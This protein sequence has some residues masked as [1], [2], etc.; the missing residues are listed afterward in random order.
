MDLDDVDPT[1]RT[2]N[3]A[4]LFD[5]T[6]AHHGDAQAMEHHGERT[7]HAELRDRTAAFAGGLHELGLAPGDRMLLFL[8]N[9][10]EYLV[11]SLGAFRAG[12]VF[13][14]VNPQY[15][16][17]EVAYQL[18]DADATAI[19]TH[20]LLREVVDEALEDTDREP[21]VVTI[22]S[23]LADRDPD[24]VFFEDVSGE[25]TL[26]E[27]TDDDVALLPYTSGTTGD[28]KGVQLTHRNTRA[29][30]S[31]PLTSSNVDVEGEDVRSLVWLPLYHIT[32]FTH[33]ALQPLVGGGSLYFRSALEWD[34]RE[35]M[36][37]IEDEEITHFVGVTTMYADMVEAEG[38][39]EYDLS[40]LESA[41]EGGAKLSTAVQERFEETAGVD[42][43]EGYGLTETHGAT[44][45]Q[46]GSSFGL[47]HGTIGQPLRMTDCKIV[48]E[49]GDE[50]ASGEEGELLVRGP[51]VMTGYHDMPE[52]TE[53]AFT[54][55]GYFRTG[56]IARR[57]E[58]N[59][60]EIVDRKKHV[61]VSAGYNVYPSE[62][63]ALLLE[64]EAVADVAVIGVPDDRRNEVPKAFVVPGAGV[65]PGADV[66]A[67]ELK[68]Y[69]LDRVA[70][71]KHPR[72]VE[73]IDELP[74]TTSGKVQKYKLE[75]NEV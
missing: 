20:P 37:L 64:H 47:R 71:Y 73:F 40:S 30:M 69:S 25:P 62:L 1:A 44:H 61:I 21:A 23:E 42:I 22:E 45:T 51:Q 75:A 32:G 19:V 16:R 57:D 52:A 3:V 66:T 60:Y 5:E 34:A 27:R 59:Y 48:D 49:S 35:C 8:P 26:V 46:L 7:T 29:Q 28:P 56:D 54:E 68:R 63:E 13:S 53:A 6:A 74:R 41:S 12:V 50:V 18:A 33:T 15:K 24:D 65:D 67:D 31:W 43:S 58:N 55:N 10:P 39:G 4:T 17:R 11:A 70:E 72:E 14:P 2:G 36:Q 9:C 38:F